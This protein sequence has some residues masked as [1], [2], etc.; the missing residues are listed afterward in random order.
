MTANPIKPM[1]QPQPLIA[2]RDVDASRRWYCRLLDGNY[3]HGDKDLIYDGI[4]CQGTLVL[5][6][7]RWEAEN[8]PNLT[9]AKAGQ[10]GHGVLLW[11]AVANFDTV[12]GRARSLAAE[13]VTDVH[14]NAN[15]GHHEIWLR[16]LDGYV[17]VIAGSASA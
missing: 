16:D 1:I 15:A 3:A 17:V 12:V 13:I 8:H 2:V 9:D 6:L 7:H 4:Y 10:A 11:F 14:F 5:Q